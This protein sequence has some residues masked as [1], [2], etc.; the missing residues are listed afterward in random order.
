MSSTEGTAN[1]GRSHEEASRRRAMLAAPIPERVERIVE[2]WRYLEGTDIPEK[3]EQ[4][5]RE[6][7]AVLS[8]SVLGEVLCA[9]VRGADALEAISM[10][11]GR[12]KEPGGV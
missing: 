10:S 6:E 11:V 4:A 8:A 9:V 7:I 1:M 12:T 3:Q 2:L 5:H